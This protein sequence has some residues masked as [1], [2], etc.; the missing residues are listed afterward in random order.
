M[1]Y[2]GGHEL[3]APGCITQA[4]VE[5]G[6]TGVGAQ[7]WSL[8]QPPDPSI[9]AAGQARAVRPHVAGALEATP[10]SPAQMPPDAEEVVTATLIAP[11]GG[12]VTHIDD[13]AVTGLSG[14]GYGVTQEESM[15]KL[16]TG[17]VHITPVGAPQEHVEHVTGGA[18]RSALP[19]KTGVAANPAPH[20]GGAPWV[21]A[22]T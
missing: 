6:P 21:V 18:V 10:P 19:S 20:G 15:K 7:T 5:K 8:G 12:A 2:P 14:P 13:E 1:A 22:A 4:R 16:M 11:K 17:P 3:A 9:D